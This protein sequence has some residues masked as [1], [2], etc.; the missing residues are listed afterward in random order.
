MDVDSPE[1]PRNPHNDNQNLP[2]GMAVP[3]HDNH[4]PSTQPNTQ[5]QPDHAQP[6]EEESSHKRATAKSIRNTPPTG[7]VTNP[8]QGHAKPEDQEAEPKPNTHSKLSFSTHPNFTT[9][10]AHHTEH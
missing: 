5:E 1:N 9:P 2:K 10:T 7:P 3:N 4:L 8:H 6:Q